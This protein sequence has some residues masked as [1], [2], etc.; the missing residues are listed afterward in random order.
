ML[1]AVL[2]LSALILSFALTLFIKN[3]A[4][5][6]SLTDNPNERSSHTLPTPRLGG[7]AI[8]A[9]WFPGLTALYFLGYVEQNLFNALL[10]GLP[11]AGVSIV[12][13]LYG[14]GF[15]VRL[16]AHFMAAGL[17][18]YFLNGLR[19]FYTFDLHINMPYLVFPIFVIGMV[20][21]INLFNFM[22][23]LDGF[24]STEA[25][26]IAFVL[27]YFSESVL[28]WLLIASIAGFLYWN[29]PKAKIFMGDAGSTQLGFVLIVLG[30]YYHNNLSFS[31]LNWLMIAAPF[32]FDAT[33]TLFQR[34]RN[35]EK[36][37]QAHRKHAYQRLTKL[38]LSHLQVNLILYAMN[39]S[40]LSMV[41]IYRSHYYLKIPLTVFTIVGMYF[42]YKALDKKVPF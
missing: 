20:W 22:D 11:V 18:F 19:Y 32:W 30:L 29:W 26:F 8:I 23:G 38:G 39:M 33:F 15:K 13:D 28:P 27:A 3:W 17:A 21:F 31:I 16:L 40:I 4:V 5:R 1:I 12:D 6:N 42:L 24:A 14:L 7:I 36:L 2:L 37:S 34:W 35:K 25:I 41:F 9:V 10:C